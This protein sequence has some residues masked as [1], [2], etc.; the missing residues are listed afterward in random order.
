[1]KITFKLFII[2]SIF[3]TSLF[4]QEK[5]LKIAIP[6]DMVPY[7]FVDDQGQASGIFV[8]YWNLW[9]KKTGKK[10]QFK[11]YSWGDSIK[12]LR[13]KEVDIHS[14][15]FRNEDRT[16]EFLFSKRLY[17]SQSFVYFFNGNSN[18]YKSLKDLSSKTIGLLK[19]TF[20]DSYIKRNYP[21][22]KIK[23]F[24]SLEKM[25]Q[26]IK[27]NEVEFFI[28]DSLIMWFQL[29]KNFSFNKVSILTDF[30]LDKW[31]YAGLRKDDVALKEV[32][33][34]GM[35]K[36][37]IDDIINIERNWIIE[38]S[39]RYFEQKKNNDF[40][41]YKERIW[42]LKNQKANI[43]LV[44]DWQKY[45]ILNENGTIE[46]LHVDLIKLINNNLNTNIKI[47]VYDT[48]KEAYSSV[49][50][51]K[52][53]A[54][55]G[56]SWSKQREKDFFYSPSY[57]YSPY[58]LVARKSDNTIKNFEDIKGKIGITYENSITS[59][60]IKE[61]TKDVLILNE[62]TVR[63]ILKKIKN[64]KADFALIENAKVVDLDKYDIKIVDSVFSK[65]SELYIGTSKT[66]EI[67]ANIIKKGM[68]LISNE[69]LNELKNRWLDKH[70][71]YSKDEIKYIESSKPL[72]IGIEDWAGII[73]LN[74]KN[75]IEGIGGEVFH[76]ILAHSGLKYNFVKK[77]W[78]E[79]LQ[80]FKDKK[81][82]ILPTTI[83]TKNRDS[84][85]EFTKDYLSL[86][87]F[88]YVKDDKSFVNSLKD[89]E[90]K[91]VAI[92][93]DDGIIESLKQKF[94][95][96]KIIET[97][98][99]EESISMVLNNEVDALFEAQISVENKLR[100]FLI[101][102]LRAVAQNDIEAKNLHIF[103]QE[104]NKQLK[105]ILDKSIK[106]VPGVVKNKIIS[107]WLFNIKRVQKNINIAF[108]QGKAPYVVNNEYMKGIEFD[109]V[110]K[111]FNLSFI[112]IKNTKNVFKDDLENILLD[113]KSIDVAVSIKQTNNLNLFYS[114]TFIKFKNV[115]VSKKTDNLV[116]KSF[117]DLKNKRVGSFVGAKKYLDKNYK[118]AIKNS[119][120]YKEYNY[121]QEQVQD[122]LDGKLDV[123]VLDENIFKWYFHKLSNKTL[124]KFSFHRIFKK[125]N[126]YKVAFRDKKLR[127]IFNKNLK[128]IKENADYEY[129]INNYIEG[130]MELKI[131][132]N[133]LL[134]SIL[135]Q[136]I[137][138]KNIEEIRK[139]V[140]IFSKLENINKIDVFDSKNKLLYTNT[141]KLYKRFLKQDS[142]Y[143]KDTIPRKVGFIKVYYNYKALNS[144]SKNLINPRI[145]E[146]QSLKS[147]A[148]IKKIYEEFDLLNNKISLNKEE[149]EYIKNMKP[150]KIGVDTWKAILGLKNKES[151]DGLAGEIINEVLKQT[152][153]K[154]EFI[155]G[156]WSNLLQ[157][158]KDKKLDILPATIFTKERTNFAQFSN[159]YLS[160][161]N[162]LYVKASNNSIKSFKDLENKTLAIQ[163]DFGSIEAIKSKYPKIKIIETKNVED[164]I[165]KV[166]NEEADAL[167]DLQLVIENHMKEFLITNLKSVSQYSIENESLQI[168]FH[169]T[170][171]KNLKSILNKAIK[172]L[173]FSKKNEIISKWINTLDIKNS[174]NIL[175]L[176][177]MKPYSFEDSYLKGIDFE[178]INK[179]FSLSSISINNIKNTNQL[180]HEELLN[181]SAFYD[182]AISREK[183]KQKGLFYSNAFSGYENVVVSRL[184]DGYI[185]EDVKDLKNKKVLAFYNAH[186]RLGKDFASLNKKGI[187][188][189]EI[190]DQEKQIK[191]FLEKKVDLIVL[192]INVF[193][194]YLNNLSQSSIN[195]FTIHKIFPNKVLR[196]I[197]FKDEK[198]RDIFNE[199]L[200]RIKRSGEYDAIVEDY[201][202]DYIDSKTKITSFISSIV[203]Y[204]LYNEQYDEIKKIV[205]V[206][207]PLP[208]INKIEVLTNENKLIATNASNDFKFFTFSD[209]YHFTLNAPKKVGQVRVY[210]DN[211]SLKKY[212]N[213][214]SVIPRIDSFSKFINYNHIKEQ[215]E[216]FNYLNNQLVFTKEELDFIR[217]NKVIKYTTSHWAPLFMVDE[218]NIHSG[219][220]DDY[221]KLI[222]EKTGLQFEYVLS[223]TWS[224]V[225]SNFEKN[226]V[227]IIPGIGN[228]A[229]KLPNVLVS[230]PI[231][232][233]R[234]AIISDEN[235]HFLDGLKDLKSLKIA[236]PKGYSSNILL[237]NS[238]YNLNVVDTSDETEALAKVSNN[239][240]DVA[241]EHSAIMVHILKND[242]PELK[243]VGFT[244]E[245][246]KHYFAVSNLKPELLSILNK[247]IFNISEEEKIKLREK[248]LY[249]KINTAVDYE[250]VYRV[251]AIFT[252]LLAI[253][254]FFTRKLSKANSRA[255]STNKKLLDTVKTLSKTQ[256]ELLTKTKDLKE[257]KE[258]FETLFND[259][260]DGLTLIKDGKYVGCNTAILK[261]LN[262]P[263]KEYLLSLTPLDIS[264]PY[265]E[266]GISSE[267]KAYEHIQACMENGSHKFEWLHK[268][269][270]GEIVCFE[271]VLTKIIL[272]SQSVIHVVARDIEDKKFLEKQN[273]KRTYELEEANIELE[274]SIKNL[275]LTQKQLIESEKMASLGALVAGVA[276]E[277]NTPVG[278]G[279]TGASHFLEI[280]KDIKK[281]YEEDKVTQEEF[282]EY[283]SISNELASLINSNLKRAA[284]L[285]KSF[286]QVAVDQTSE[287]KREFYL[288]K[289]IEEILASIHSVTK[290][291]K[292]NIFIYCDDSIRINSYPGAISQILTNLIMNSII[293]GYKKNE[294]G[295]LSVEVKKYDEKIKIIYKDDGKGIPK[296][297]LE[298]IFDPFFTTNRENGGSGLG[299]NVVY[300]IVTT[301]LNGEIIC[302]SE[303]KGVEFVITFNV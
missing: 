162:Y 138:D 62:N 46:G 64:K 89:L 9:S 87:Y 170:A 45:S 239:Q 210:F 282:E 179:I 152:G 255:E 240:V 269:Y 227:D 177:D 201:T 266:D 280:S 221:M 262:I 226:E 154:F 145:E 120:Y 83:Y 144:Y 295:I 19:G 66:N 131:R 167:F 217:N 161:K 225:L 189:K 91:K 263:S 71:I 101:T 230:D 118:N 292:L 175:L 143:I 178:L 123:I 5:T 294:N 60:L 184:E 48:W 103:L 277:I 275:K 192:D 47:K 93:K 166:L 242:F 157:D 148:N 133:F 244:D 207:T 256:N 185:I 273:K 70:N 112:K 190:K 96:I 260:S 4:A 191:L 264:A 223:K 235:Q 168:M 113:D 53:T 164:A 6:N 289:Y 136:S 94:P 69:Q 10:V 117:E 77:D 41:N 140:D 124:N 130:Y 208:F 297:N 7:A 272:N 150:L 300:N 238:P 100:E 31:F 52:S 3:L 12:A 232:A 14:G 79:L 252:L 169:K 8:D 195:D 15:F 267:Q 29:I 102:N 174:L 55:A 173:S 248:W 86:P 249:S 220:F 21:K 26:A 122:F 17:I 137:K 2:F 58:H 61:K 72:I 25:F 37:S 290:K 16:A 146:F 281:S 39:F 287:E 172:E 43:A 213:I 90:N 229:Y 251:I 209:S 211:T 293:H 222:E 261:M 135:S 186:K 68:G 156:D 234:Y 20:Y 139:V 155:Q 119:K 67:F 236:S 299:L 104:D 56:L 22:I 203:S 214:Q 219:F 78:S 182:L 284:N 196:Y 171:N 160:I 110:K 115:L 107:N 116:F 276:H 80:D 147:F 296:D 245:T 50:S 151:L 57:N 199:N 35:S 218:K 205:N 258:I 40:L 183:N 73:K 158:F 181:Q 301:K 274:M 128:R 98:N 74:D 254:L 34:K 81:I 303:E 63:G 85:G 1:M 97:K 121:Q 291:T 159:S 253:V 11:S 250:I 193:R 84:Y 246:F 202:L 271:I 187:Y 75:Q 108:S 59:K 265:Q 141:N 28:D 125:E 105:S 92:L 278:I 259:T 54:I 176:K 270:T 132:S 237:K 298:K 30:Q 153:L 180:E 163:K 197:A 129:I 49:L 241:V 212:K 126:E 127:D 142:Y 42:L 99:L 194:W 109:L 268:K 204:Y 233:F 88:I 24:T 44:K 106:A 23:R 32:I 134:S 216:K 200:E 165:Q 13:N 231:M 302:M 82:D 247:A 224:D 36:I 149:L 288:R 18:K 111:I 215:Y 228:S 198:I 206:F 65:Y 188:Y 95:K 283:L 76:K 279:L 257:Q 286:K 33:D 51:G 114:D 285:V 27:N 38:P 243:I